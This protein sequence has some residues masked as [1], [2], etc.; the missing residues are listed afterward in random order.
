MK[1]QKESNVSTL[2]RIMTNFVQIIT[3]VASYRL[4]YPEYLIDFLGPAT[5]IGESSEQMV[6]IDCYIADVVEGSE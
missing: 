1:K 4:G 3:T 5:F 2:L 6:S